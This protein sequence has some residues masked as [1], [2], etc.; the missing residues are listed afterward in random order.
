MDIT[1]T[2]HDIIM[3]Q[4]DAALRPAGLV[5]KKKRAELEK[6]Q[7]ELESKINAKLREMCDKADKDFRA[8]LDKLPGGKSI[9]KRRWR[10]EDGAFSYSSAD[11]FTLPFDSREPDEVFSAYRRDI[12]QK[13]IRIASENPSKIAYTKV[14][15][16]LAGT[17]HVKEIEKLLK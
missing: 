4:V 15:E 3:G 11:N 8:W 6:K 16:F 10:G 7:S 9:K 17:D 2:I 1:S 12:L 14:D 5:A 13:A